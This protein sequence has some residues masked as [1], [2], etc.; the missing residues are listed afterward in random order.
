[1]PTHYPTD[2]RQN[3]VRRCWPVVLLDLVE[4]LYQFAAPDVGDW[5]RADLGVNQ[6]LERL[7]A[8]RSFAPS[9]FRNRSLTE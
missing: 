1:V 2:K 5:A 8:R 3:Q 7:P 4:Q 9:S 6:A